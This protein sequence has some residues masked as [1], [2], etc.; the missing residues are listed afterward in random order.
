MTMSLMMTL[1]NMAG[2]AVFVIF[3]G[4]G[5]G[6]MAL[7]EIAAAGIAF[8]F[9]LSRLFGKDSSLAFQKPS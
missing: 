8:L 3:L 9:G 5:T 7:A 6:G 2:M 4:M 1:L